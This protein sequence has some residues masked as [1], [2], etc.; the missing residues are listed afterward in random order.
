MKPDPRRTLLLF[1]RGDENGEDGKLKDI[2]VIIN[3]LICRILSEDPRVSVRG[4]P[5]VFFKIK[6]LIINMSYFE[7]RDNIIIIFS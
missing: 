6:L 4:C 5:L 1:A 7:I 3:L 2:F